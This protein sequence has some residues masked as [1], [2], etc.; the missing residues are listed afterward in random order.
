VARGYLLRNLAESLNFEKIGSQA[1]VWIALI[2]TSILFGWLHSANPNA[3]AASTFMLVFAGLLLGLGYILTGELAIPIG[4]HITWNFFQ[5]NIFGFPVSGTTPQASF[6]QINQSGP[7]A[8]TGG[9]F[10]PEAGLLGLFA[11]ILGAVLIVIWVSLVHKK[12]SIQTSIAD[13]KPRRS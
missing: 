1:S 10:G 4:F 12:L 5:G 7:S 8:W 2:L 6:I 11:Y 3:T 13:F 9:A